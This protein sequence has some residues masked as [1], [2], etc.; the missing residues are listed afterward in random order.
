M[1]GVCYKKIFTLAEKW[2]WHFK[3]GA[4][5]F[6][7]FVNHFIAPEVIA[8]V[9]HMADPTTG[10]IFYSLITVIVYNNYEVLC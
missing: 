6:I 9:H 7:L 1:S 2:N 4:S 3:S 8:V 10:D 5:H